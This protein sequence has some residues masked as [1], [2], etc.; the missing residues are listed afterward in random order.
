[1]SRIDIFYQ[2]EGS[3]EIEHFEIEPTA[4]FAALKG[5]LREKHGLPDEILIFI[6]DGDEPFEDDEPVGK[7]ERPEGTKVHVHRC[8]HVHV[9]VT[10]NNET[11]DHKFAPSAT[12]A[13][14]KRW[15]AETRFGMSPED[16]GEHVL[17]I[18]GTKDRPNPGTHIGALVKSPECR[19]AFDLVPD[20]RIHGASG[21][22]Q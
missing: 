11:V 7:Y 17:Q 20:E 4:T 5:H 21:A 13:R 14:V 8:R 15:A 3:A 1:M 6:E 22:L 16:A 12:I 18:K 2:R 9:N 10:F 19:I